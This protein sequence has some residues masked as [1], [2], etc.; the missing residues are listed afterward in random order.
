MIKTMPAL[1]DTPPLLS[2]SPDSTLKILAIVSLL[3]LGKAVVDI[4]LP[5]ALQA[6]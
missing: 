1:S 2:I 4:S 3:A 5:D 6:G